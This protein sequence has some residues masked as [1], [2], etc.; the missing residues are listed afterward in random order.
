MLT[1]LDVCLD[2]VELAEL[3]SF[4]GNLLAGDSEALG[5]SLARV[6]DPDGYGVE[7]LRADLAQFAFLLM[8]TDG[9]RLFG[10]D[11]PQSR[12]QAGARA[13][14]SKRAAGVS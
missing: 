7:Q 9:E 11:P 2:A 5:A 13:S 1:T 14:R 3:L 6:V 4:L 10:E 12:C 8:G